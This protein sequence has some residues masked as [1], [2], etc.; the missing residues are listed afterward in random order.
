MYYT[1]SKL[2]VEKEQGAHAILSLERLSP[3]RLRMRKFVPSVEI[4][5]LAGKGN[6]LMVEARVE[7][8]AKVVEWVE[9]LVQKETKQ[10][11]VNR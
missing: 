8:A 11:G 6:W 9:A 5:E 4:V 3:L 10:G 1:T 2:R 7:I